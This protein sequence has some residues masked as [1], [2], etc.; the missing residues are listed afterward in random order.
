MLAAPAAAH[1]DPALPAQ[2]ATAASLEPSN[3]VHCVYDLMSTED[4]EMALLL[5]E[6][7]VA[8]GAK[9]HG[10]SRNLKVID[11][12]VDEGLAA[13]RALGCRGVVRAGFTGVGGLRGTGMVSSE[14]GYRA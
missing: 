13:R 7:E 11:R 8:S 10:T 3:S 4:R 12:L 1:A 6:R 5:F 14:A 9:S 2:V